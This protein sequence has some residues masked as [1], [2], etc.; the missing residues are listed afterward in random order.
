MAI[1]DH[2]KK[3]SEKEIMAETGIVIDCNS[4]KAES[5]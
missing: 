5:K 3:E 1:L 4:F 2:P